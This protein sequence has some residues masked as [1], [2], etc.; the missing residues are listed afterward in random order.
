MITSS[1]HRAL[2]AL[3]CALTSAPLL[4]V[5]ASADSYRRRGG[6][7]PAGH[8]YRRRAGDR[9]QAKPPPP[10]PYL[11]LARKA[12]IAGK[13]GQAV[14]QLKRARD[15]WARALQKPTVKPRER[16]G[17][18][19]W[20]YRLVAG[21]VY[22]ERGQPLAAVRSLEASLKAKADQPTAWLYLGQALYRAERYG[23]AAVALRRG[24][25][26][27]RDRVDYH[28]LLARALE[29]G[30]KA[31]AARSTLAAALSRF[32][33][34]RRLKRELAS[35]YAAQ[36]LYLTA[37]KMARGLLRGAPAAE[38]RTLALMV[39][40]YFR[41][42]GHRQQA[43]ALLERTR[44]VYPRDARV[45]LRLAYT[46][47]DA[48]QPLAAARLAA[49]V[50]AKRKGLAFFV[51]AQY[52]LAG[53]TQ[54]ALSWNAAVP[55]RRR[56]LRQ[57]ATILLGAEAWQRAT[58]TLAQLLRGGQLGDRGRYQLAYAALKA[59]RLALA[60]RALTALGQSPAVR[61]LWAAWRACTRD[62]TAC[63]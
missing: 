41:R 43:L 49:R 29:R 55:E 45:Q 47:A 16:C 52:R 8:G 3:F 32:P 23:R 5:E 28:L 10:P 27:G 22:L 60:R 12:V 46:Y 4:A 17:F 31:E 15:C 61:R 18:D 25:K 37:A 30:G 63:P 44:L 21:I 33:R 40:D 14:A 35:I 11:L 59:R 50:A 20:A 13:T 24:G 62:S 51:A 7:R 9:K 56:R 38:R 1:N 39:A 19:D 42:G 54:R 53:R 6:K 34:S 48:E 36:G 58:I 26:R 57:R 2:L